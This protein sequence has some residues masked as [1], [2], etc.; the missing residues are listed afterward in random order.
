MS[1]YILNVADADKSNN[2]SILFNLKIF[3]C[4]SSIAWCFVYEKSKNEL[5]FCCLGMFF[6][7]KYRAKK[8]FPRK[9]RH[10][11]HFLRCQQTVN[12]FMQ[13]ITFLKTG[14]FT[15]L[16]TQYFLVLCYYKAK[17]S[18][19]NKGLTAEIIIF[20]QTLFAVYKTMGVMRPV[21]IHVFQFTKHAT[22][23]TIIL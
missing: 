22:T 2:C 21:S 18:S 15:A 9:L 8:T 3:Q 10:F 19:S 17:M 11:C 7:S 6:Y 1:G 16:T 12:D 5:F 13:L 20:N 14:V 4:S 23:F